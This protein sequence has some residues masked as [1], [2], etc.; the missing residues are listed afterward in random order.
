MKRVVWS[1]RPRGRFGWLV[2]RDGKTEFPFLFKFRAVAF[3]RRMCAFEWDSYHYPSELMIANSQGRY[4]D[5]GS[6]YGNDP[7]KVKG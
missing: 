1:V 2:T 3:A 6:T 5:A 7:P 4:T